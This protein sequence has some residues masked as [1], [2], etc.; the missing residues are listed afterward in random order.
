MHVNTTLIIFKCLTSSN[1]S[2]FLYLKLKSFPS[3]SNIFLLYTYVPSD[4]SNMMKISENF[5]PY[6]KIFS[7]ISWVRYLTYNNFLFL[8]SYIFAPLQQIVYS[9]SAFSKF[10]SFNKWF[11]TSISLPVL[12]INFTPNFLAFWIASILKSGT[13]L[14]TKRVL[15]KSE[16][17]I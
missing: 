12:I 16:K 17:I 10:N 11:I 5:F 15:S 8:F 4:V 9:F 14:L 13:W 2:K 3:F 1:F 6:S 7:T